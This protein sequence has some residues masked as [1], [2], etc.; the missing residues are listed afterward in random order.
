MYLLFSI[1][2]IKNGLGDYYTKIQIL[3]NYSKNL[4]YK[5]QSIINNKIICKYH[6]FLFFNYYH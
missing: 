6:Q 3:E 2:Y 5:Y 1:K 4:F